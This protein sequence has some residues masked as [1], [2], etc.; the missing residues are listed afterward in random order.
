MISWYSEMRLEPSGQKGATT[1]ISKSR[2][3]ECVTSLWT[4]A[5]KEEVVVDEVGR[6]GGGGGVSGSEGQGGGRPPAAGGSREAACNIIMPL[7]GWWSRGLA[8]R[9]EVTMSETWRNVDNILLASLILWHMPY[10]WHISR[11]WQAK[12]TSPQTQTKL[13]GAR[14]MQPSI[15]QSWNHCVFKRCIS[16]RIIWISPAKQFITYMVNDTH[17]VTSVFWLRS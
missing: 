14:C 1:D 5:E 17:Y 13:V 3:Q 10:Y 6:D 9:L 15:M 12:N 7:I 16:E 8:S 11:W 2:H 4:D